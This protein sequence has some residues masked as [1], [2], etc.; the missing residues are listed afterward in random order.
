MMCYF[1]KVKYE[2]GFSINQEPAYFTLNGSSSK[3][4]KKKLLYA[5][6]FIKGITFSV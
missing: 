2:F 1:P 3:K 5:L 6:L 4:K